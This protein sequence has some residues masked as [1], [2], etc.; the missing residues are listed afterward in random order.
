[1]LA[2]WPVIRKPGVRQ[3]L[4][5]TVGRLAAKVQPPPPPA[6]PPPPIPLV[7]PNLSALA[8]PEAVLPQ[9]VQDDPVAQKYRRLL[10]DLA[11]ATFPERPTNRP[12]PGP[13]PAPRAPFAAAFLVK[14]GPGRRYMP[15]LRRLPGRPSGLGLAA[16]FSARAVRP[17]P[18]GLR[19]RRQPA[20]LSPLQPC[21]TH[22]RQY[23]LAVPARCYGPGSSADRRLSPELRSSFGD[24]V[25]GG[26]QAHHRLGAARTTPSCTSPTATTKPGSPKG[27]P[28]AG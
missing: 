28:T 23:G 7:R 18:L 20:H 27:I 15:Q 6:A 5:R 22:P 2:G 12:W 14:L 26:H 19:C 9:F 10:A 1:M 11:W 8:R 4:R 25:A 17:H 13:T 16:R 24:V 21:A 3:W